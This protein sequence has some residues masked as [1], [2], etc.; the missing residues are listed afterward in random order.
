MFYQFRPVIIIKP[1]TVIERKF[2]QMIPVIKP[3]QFSYIDPFPYKPKTYN[4]IHKKILS[5][6]LA[7][8]SS[9]NK[10]LIEAV[11]VCDQFIFSVTLVDQEKKLR[12]M[13]GILCGNVLVE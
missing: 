12:K 10:I 5:P 9:N 2:K 3:N 4:I 7:Q 11:A 13:L 8:Q 1:S 6:N